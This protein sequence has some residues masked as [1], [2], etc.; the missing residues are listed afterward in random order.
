MKQRGTKNFSPTAQ[1][2]SSFSSEEWKSKL[3]ES[4]YDM[5]IETQNA[6]QKWRKDGWP[7]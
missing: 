3:Q 2:S 5:L 7:E 4:S 1:K 6:L